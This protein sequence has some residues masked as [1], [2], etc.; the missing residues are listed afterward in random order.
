M[1]KKS[2]EC[3]VKVRKG[4]FA[5]VADELENKH[6]KIEKHVAIRNT[7]CYNTQ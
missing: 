5:N 4:R 2:G 7:P 1:S 3:Y 6:K